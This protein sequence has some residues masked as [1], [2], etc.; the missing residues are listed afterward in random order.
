MKICKNVFLLVSIGLVLS[1]G[2]VSS[3]RLP[4]SY[5]NTFRLQD[6]IK[7][8]LSYAEQERADDPLVEIEP[9]VWV[10][11]SNVSGVEVMGDTYYYTLLPHMS[12]EPV[13][14]GEAGLN[15]ITIVYED[16]ETTHPI[17]IYQL[18]E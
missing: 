9:D 14:R 13:A 1:S 8:V 3:N 12:F 5:A 7:E 16:N 6:V 10:K 4:I 15:R 18:N 2:L 11:S 17:V